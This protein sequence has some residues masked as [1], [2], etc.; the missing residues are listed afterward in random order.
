MSDTDYLKCACAS[1]QGHL[2]FP[3]Y[4]LGITTTC[5]H[6]GIETKLVAVAD[7]AP[8]RTP[9]PAIVVEPPTPAAT[10]LSPVD[11]AP[12]GARPK[13]VLKV[14]LSVLVALAVVGFISFKLWSQFRRAAKTVEVV[15]GEP[16]PPPSKP[17]ANSPGKAPPPAPSATATA[18]VLAKGTPPARKPGEDL[19]ILNFE[20]QKAKDGNLQYIVG[21]VTNHAAKQYFN[22]KL[23]FVLTRKDGKSGDLATDTIRNLAP[24][25]GVTFK[26]SVI[27]NTAVATAKLAKLE[28]EKE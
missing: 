18:E 9:P 12:T 5:P 3:A 23:E 24:N 1:C 6:C 8:L 2:E 15:K 10:V 28:G 21:V 14:V 16:K 13:K 22:V 19:Q 20:V 17:P 11:P 4:A 27:G 7:T 25:A 26:A